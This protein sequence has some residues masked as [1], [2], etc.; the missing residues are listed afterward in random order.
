MDLKKF[1]KG[2]TVGGVLGALGGYLA[3]HVDPSALSPTAA[4]ILGA[5]LT[6]VGQVTHHTTQGSSPVGS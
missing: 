4:A 2:V 5:I 1:F 3:G 6:I